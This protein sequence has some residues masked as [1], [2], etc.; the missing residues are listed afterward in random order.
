MSPHIQHPGF[1][2]NSRRHSSN[3]AKKSVCYLLFYIEINTPSL[4]SGTLQRTP[5][6]YCYRG[7]FFAR[8]LCLCCSYYFFI[9]IVEPAFAT[10]KRV[11]R[12]DV[13]ERRCP[14]AGHLFFIGVGVKGWVDTNELEV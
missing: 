12:F 2:P 5:A 6:L 11:R 3:T 8:P 1:F 4:S 10:E 9:S 14:R 7:P 13:Y